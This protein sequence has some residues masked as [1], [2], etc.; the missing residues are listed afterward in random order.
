MKTECF[1]QVEPIHIKI[2]LSSVRLTLQDET[3]VG[4][5]TKLGKSKLKVISWKLFAASAK[6][7]LKTSGYV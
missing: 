3:G 1:G 4:E 5:C 6:I 7:Y 2:I